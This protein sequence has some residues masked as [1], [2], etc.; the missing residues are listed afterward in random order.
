VVVV[1]GAVLCNTI[2]VAA[3]VAG[4]V[5][6]SCARPPANAVPDHSL[7]LSWHIVQQLVIHVPVVVGRVMKS[8]GKLR[9]RSFLDVFQALSR[10]IFCSDAVA[11]TV[12][13]R[14]FQ[15]VEMRSR[16]PDW[17]AV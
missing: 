5:E 1:P 8:G 13:R 14:I 11:S 10:S 7:G 3:A 4:V 6:R 2:A 12:Q 17:D 15:M 16:V 9:R